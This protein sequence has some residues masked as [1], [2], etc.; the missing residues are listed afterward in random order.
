MP[1]HV[2]HQKSIYN[3]DDMPR[4]PVCT[5]SEPSVRKMR[6]PS[7]ALHSLLILIHFFL[8]A[9]SLILTFV[10]RTALWGPLSLS[11]FLLCFPSLSWVSPEKLNRFSLKNLM[12]QTERNT[13]WKRQ[14]V[15]LNPFSFLFPWP[16]VCVMPG[17]E[18]PKYKR[19]AG[20]EVMQNHA[21][22]VR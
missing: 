13:I 16:A 4:H 1:T 8:H 12:C 11:L 6:R 19:G 17:Y 21:A 22:V 10:C 5:P 15:Y 7:K 9:H 3:L 18:E 20:V 14:T 2:P